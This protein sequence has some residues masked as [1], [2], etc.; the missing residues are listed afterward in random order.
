MAVEVRPVRAETEQLPRVV[1]G[2]EAA[3][4]KWL[5]W[6]E[7]PG[8]DLAAMDGGRAVG[9]IHVGIVGRTEAWLEAL[10]VHPDAQGRGI[11]GRLVKEGEQVAQHYGAAVIRTAI[12]AH[13][14]AAVGVAERAGFHA[15]TR[16]VVVET[17]VESVPVHI[18]YDAPVESPRAETAPLLLRLLE[19]TPTLTAWGR[20][21]PLG[22]R[23]RR[24]SAELVRGLVKDRR[25]AAALLPERSEAL[26]AATLF[27]GHD[28]AVVVSVLDGT[29][30]GMQALFGELAENALARGVV[31]V[32]VFTHD[33]AALRAIGAREWQPHP[34]CPD[35]LIIVEKSLAS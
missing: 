15:V 20:L 17:K 32:A 28:E 26:Q 34:W 22:W 12:P 29:P 5:A 1:G 8:H 7:E 31:R 10:R 35:G 13:D 21:I 19:R 4:A 3:P 16:A 33:A 2:R 23:F 24:L 6:A 30:P 11:A 18:P 27:A 25:A 14:Y 9:G